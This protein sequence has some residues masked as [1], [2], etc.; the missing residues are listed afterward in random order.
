LQLLE[1]GARF[2]YATVKALVVPR[3]PDIPVVNIQ[4]PDLTIYDALLRASA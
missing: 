1:D 3:E 4:S 2:D